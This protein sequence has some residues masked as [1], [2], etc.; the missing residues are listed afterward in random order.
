MIPVIMKYHLVPVITPKLCAE[1]AFS[2]VVLQFLILIQSCIKILKHSNFTTH[3]KKN[4][5]LLKPI[6]VF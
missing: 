5:I 4:S 2:T 6:S 3:T 1:K